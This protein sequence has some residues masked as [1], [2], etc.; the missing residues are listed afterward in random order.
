[1]VDRS[2][3][4]LSDYGIRNISSLVML[5]SGVAAL[6]V[7]VIGVVEPDGVLSLLGLEVVDSSQRAGHD[8]TPI[9][10]VVSSVVSMN[11]GVYYALAALSNLKA[12]Y[13]WTVAF[14]CVAFILF[15]VGVLSGYAPTRLLVVAFWEL[16]GAI[17][18]GLALNHERRHEMA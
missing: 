13:G 11:V 5:I 1:M 17:A 15:T 3:P 6:L 12:F 14:R 4:S 18:T 7:G 16:I 9:F 2:G 10:I 8:Y